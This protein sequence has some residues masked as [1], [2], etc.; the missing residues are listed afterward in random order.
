MAGT[1]LP[2]ETIH[3]Y[4]SLLSVYEMQYIY[5]CDYII[6]KREFVFSSLQSVV[7]A[8][9]KFL[10]ISFHDP[11]APIIYNTVDTSFKIFLE[12]CDFVLFKS[13]L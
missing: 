12:A 9:N 5:V 1:L 7:C 3:I 6:K 10:T 13:L 2:I 4:L 11:L 8:Q